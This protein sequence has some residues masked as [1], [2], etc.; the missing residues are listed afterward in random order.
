MVVGEI[1]TETEVLVIGGGPAGYLAAIRSAQLGKDVVLVDERERL[2]GVCLNEGCI[3]SKAVIH[4]SKLFHDA[5]HAAELGVAAE[6]EADMDALQ[7]W[8]EGIVQKLTGG[9]EQLEERFGV[10]VVH[11]EAVLQS[12]DTVHISDAETDG[13][14]FEH[15]ILAPGSTVMELQGVDIDR[16]TVITSREALELEE[17]PDTFAVVGGGY[18]GMELGMVYA[19]LGADVTVLEAGDRILQGFPEDLVAPVED[20]AE[21]I[22]IDVMTGSA[23]ESVA[24]EDGAATIDTGDGGVT[25]EK[26]L[27]SVGRQP[28]TED[29]G[30]ENTAIETDERGFIVVD[31][32]LRTGEEH[33]YAI[34]DA[35]GEPML[36]H[37]GY[38]EG[39]IAAEVIAGE[40]SATD[41]EVPAVVYTDPEIATVGMTEEDAAENHDVTTG[42]FSFAASGR[43]ATLDRD[44]GFVKVVADSDSEAL[45]GVHIVGPHASEMIPEAT[46]ALEMGAL[47]SD[48][49]MTVHPHPTLSEAFREACEDAVGEAIHKYNPPGDDG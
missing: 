20:R 37:K 22:G 4:A 8:R 28:N 9:V 19:K 3:P 23:A 45:L 46:L 26:V 18:I 43:A 48:I 42:R 24:V 29:L 5:G 35:A 25:A 11:G 27:V 2:G 47:V 34:G 44:D 10:E 6:P 17:V 16:E 30:L 14:A 36:A 41:F 15:C 12:A 39:K 40:P 7:A 31:E 1:S 13:I 33:I 21:E 32:Q 49:V 38:Q